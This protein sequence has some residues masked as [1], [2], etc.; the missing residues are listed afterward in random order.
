MKLRYLLF[1]LDGTLID[2][3]EGICRS[4]LYALSALGLPEPDAE[5]LR[6]CIGPPLEYSFKNFFSLDADSVAL[7]VKK[8][9]ERYAVKGVLE[10]SIIPGAEECLKK[11]KSAGY[12]L[13]LSTSKPEP[14]ARR[15]LE[16]ADLAKYFDV[17][18]GSD[19]DCKLKNKTDVIREALSRASRSG[20][21]PDLSETAIIGD[22]LY[23][24]VGGKNVGVHTIGLNVGFAAPNELEESGAEYVFGDFDALG[25]FLVGGEE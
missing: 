20:V 22:R 16:I 6:E 14:F 17:I 5:T 15:I 3:R 7:G 11:L 25:K 19:F 9:R 4:F 12:F 23:D 2:S 10:F 8:Y 24:I 13:M 18:C 21:S 1:D